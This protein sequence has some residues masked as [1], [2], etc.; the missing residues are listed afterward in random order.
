MGTSQLRTQCLIHIMQLRLGLS[1]RW[2]RCVRKNVR[3]SPRTFNEPY[4]RLNARR[5]GRKSRSTRQVKRKLSDA[6][7]LALCGYIEELDDGETPIVSK[8]LRDHANYLLE[9]DHGD[10]T[11]SPPTIGEHWLSRFLQRHPEYRHLRDRGKEQKSS[12]K[13]EQRPTDRFD[14]YKEKLKE[15]GRG[16]YR[17]QTSLERLLKESL[18]QAELIK[19][20]QQEVAALSQAVMEEEAEQEEEEEEGEEGGS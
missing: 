14:V 13:D 20:L 11:T 6:Q 7:E 9:E 18:A 17:F 12:R 2:T 1:R 10:P 15:L 19:E 4:A 5:K 3:P 8:L 16:S